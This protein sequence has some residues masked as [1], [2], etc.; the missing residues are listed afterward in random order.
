MKSSNDDRSR[1]LGARRSVL[2]AI[3]AVGLWAALELGLFSDSPLPDAGGFELMLDFFAGA[4]SPAVAYEAEFVPEGT[5]P[6]VLKVLV[7]AGKTVMFAAAAIGLSMPVGLALGFLASTA[8]WAGNRAGGTSARQRHLRRVVAPAIYLSTRVLI[9]L[10][11]SI[12]ELLWA[13]IFLSAMGLTNLAAVVAVAIPYA[14]TLAKVFSEMIDET[15]RNSAVALRAAGASPLQVFL[16]G[17]LPRAIP[18][19]SAYSLYRFE[20]A[21]RSSAVLGFFGI[22]TLGYYVHLSFAN[23][24]YREVWSYLYALLLLVVV[25]D[26]WSGAIRRRMVA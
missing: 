6:L 25:M 1:L 10:M 2:L 17:L 23:A 16:F 8:W 11:R 19:V 5:Q 21:L 15:Q 9:A 26:W 14:G 20:C 3:G 12:H 18:D 13:V 24:H 4:F 7:A 22:P